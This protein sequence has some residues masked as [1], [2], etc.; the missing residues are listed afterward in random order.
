MKHR[1]HRRRHGVVDGH[2]S[3]QRLP[4]GRGSVAGHVPGG[5]RLP[6]RN[7]FWWLN[8]PKKITILE[9]Y[10]LKKL[11]VDVSWW[12]C[13]FLLNLLP[14]VAHNASMGVIFQPINELV[15]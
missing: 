15:A 1:G 10:K 13:F 12:R 4:G 2:G 5:A 8:R 14:I 11:F 9:V 3:Q 6:K 7:G